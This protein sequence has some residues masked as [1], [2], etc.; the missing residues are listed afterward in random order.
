VTGQLYGVGVGPGDPELITLKA[1]RLIQHADV[2]AYHSGTAGR[3]I[4]RTIADSLISENVIEELL[5]Y[6]VT[7]G[8]TDHP[9]GYYGAVTDFY[10]E[11][12]QRLG[13]HLDVGRTVVVLAEGD[14]LFYS[15]YMYL[16]DRLSPR[17]PSEIVPGV[18][19][20]TAAATAL[21]T[22][23]ARHEDILTVLPGTLPVTELA[24]RLAD[25]D[26]AAI[27]KLGRTFA[28]VR[29]ALRQA[30]RLSDALY[31]ERATT[32][33]QRVL[34]VTDVD[35]A[36]VP[37]FSM[38]VL[39]GRDRR[40]DSA[41][42]SAVVQPTVGADH[43]AEPQLFV[44]GLGPGSDS[45]MTAEVTA[46]LAEVDHVV[47]YGPYLD[48]LPARPDLRRHPSGNTVE[49]ERARYALD[50]ALGGKHVAVVSGGDAGVF[51]MASAVFEAAEEDRYARI[52]ITVLPGVTAAQAVAARAGA[53]LGGDYAVV[54]L[55]DR[56]KSWSVIEQRLRAVVGADLVLTIYN[57]AS[58]TR[59]EQIVR[60]CK[61]LL[62]L[63]PPD[64]PVVVGRNVGREGE[65]LTITTLEALEPDT[66]DMSCLLIIGSSLTQ[67]GHGATVWTSRSQTS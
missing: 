27:M 50:L 61:L 49:V 13:K 44:V 58:R 37:Y 29:E 66:I 53:P 28:D 60:A 26:A 9:L 31:V 21:Q 19:S 23:L 38:I 11:S 46:V 67:F 32:G 40:L 47:G 33:E 57:P 3:S 20:L 18:T 8:P 12:A 45:W 7:T 14:P 22:P 5:I 52:K 15:S 41:G 48:R 24:R 65:D 10:D 2:I 4:A 35:A 51:G 55:S 59:R 63:R 17:F 54:S 56:L 36:A 64:T 16:H 43:V 39:P 6:P 62:E 30:G 25:T 42:R 34:P 1:A